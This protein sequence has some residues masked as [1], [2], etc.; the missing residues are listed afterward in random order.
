MKRLVIA[1]G[2]GAVLLLAP[3]A[4]AQTGMAR[5][6]VVDEKGQAMAGVKVS[7]EF[8]GGVT[9]KGEVTTNKKGEFIQVGLQPGNYRFVADVAGYQ[10]QFADLRV[11]LGDP[12]LVPD[13]KMVPKGAG[14]GAAA[15]PGGGV[16]PGLAALKSAVEQAIA[17]ASAGKTDEALAAYADLQAKNPTVH[18]I[19][20]NMANLY[21]NKKDF[22]NAEASFKKAL[23]A[24]P[25][26][27][28]ALIGLSNLYVNTNRATE[29]SELVAKASAANPSDTKLALQ[30]GVILFNTGKQAEAAAIFEKIAAA[31]PT[32]AEPHYY[33]GT[34]AVGQNKTAEAVAQLEKY[35]ALNPTGA[36]VATAKGLL[37][38]LK[39]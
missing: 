15:G 13:L 36:N 14:G 21:F 26:Y 11:G 10:T 23:E 2:L 16:D 3:A 28:D 8:Q 33:L 6:K 34:I 17:L 31:D 25:D 24:K 39:K 38:F 22:A 35:L 32:S 19:P 27:A 20:Y 7:W 30:A 37:A 9:R 18:Q 29:A 12:T 5:G 1:A 4:H